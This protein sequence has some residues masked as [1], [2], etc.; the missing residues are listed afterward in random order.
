MCLFELV[1]V[2]FFLVIPK[3]G[4]VRSYSSS[5]ASFWGTSRCFCAIV[6]TLYIPTSSVRGLTFSPA[7]VVCRHFDDSPSDRCEMVSYCGFCVHFHDVYWCWVSSLVIVGHLPF[8]F[9]KYLCSSTAY[10]LIGF[11]FDVGLYEVFISLD[12]NPLS[13]ISF[14]NIF[15]H[16]VGCY[17]AAQ[18]L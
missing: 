12:I 7:F 3:S 10:F 17:F 5:V 4:I 18:H 6:V 11:L 16:S 15:S 13:V 9:G 8:S 14:A 2:F 1:C